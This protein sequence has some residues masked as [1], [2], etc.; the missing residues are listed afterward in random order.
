MKHILV[1]DDEKEIVD[2]LRVYIQNA[3]FIVH[4]AY[5]G[6]EG[7]DILN[8]GS[9]DM[10]LLDIVM[11]KINGLNVLSHIRNTSNIPVII[12]SAKDDDMDKINALGLG[13]DDYIAKPFN[14]LEVV[15]RIQ[16]IFRRSAR[17]KVE[18]ERFVEVQDIVVD[19]ESCVVK[20]SGNQIVL[21]SKEYQLLVYFLLHPKKVLTKQQLYEA[22]WEEDYLFD[23]NTIMVYISKLREKLNDNPKNPIYIKNIRGL[24]YYFDEDIS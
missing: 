21:T 18:D 19:Q 24:G 22:V 3:G 23:D 5:N 15:A 7:I 13:A 9:I 2:L 1:V 14:P 16:A 4:E 20:K 10:A 6:Q 12:L 11:P 8:T 17:E